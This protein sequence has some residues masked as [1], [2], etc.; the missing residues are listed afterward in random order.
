MPAPRGRA[1]AARAPETAGD[2]VSALPRVTVLQALAG[3]LIKFDA[4]IDASVD[5]L[6]WRSQPIR[7]VRV[8]STLQNRDLTLRELSVNDLGGAQGK[9]SGYFQGIGTPL[10]KTQLAF[11][12]RGPELGRVLRLLSPT[13]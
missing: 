3:A 8:T 6:I 12:M 9:L 1:A 13:S 11:D 4:N 5:T 7:K 10:P 2:A